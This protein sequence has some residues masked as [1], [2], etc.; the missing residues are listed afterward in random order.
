MDRCEACPLFEMASESGDCCEG[1]L[2]V[3]V[4]IAKLQ[5]GIFKLKKRQRIWF[6]GRNTYELESAKSSAT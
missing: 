5:H 6:E 2:P 3:S 1:G 4:C